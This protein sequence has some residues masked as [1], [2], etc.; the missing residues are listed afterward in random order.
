MTGKKQRLSAKVRAL[1]AGMVEHGESRAKAAERAGI[2]DSWAY[3]LLRRP[4]VLALRNE[5]MR[6]LRE[7]EASRTIARVAKLADTAES[8]HVQF[9]ANEWL[10]GIE[11]IAP[12]QR[13]DAHYLHEHRMRPGLVIEST[14]RGVLLDVDRPR[15]PAPAPGIVD[16]QVEAQPAPLIEIE[17]EAPDAIEHRLD[18]D[19]EIAI[20]RDRSGAR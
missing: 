2:S 17:S 7:S 6:V 8:E 19:V 9:K 20:L 13:V 16:V 10:G 12:V 11:G 3:Q 14:R 18:E 1:V 5:M 15:L 4:A